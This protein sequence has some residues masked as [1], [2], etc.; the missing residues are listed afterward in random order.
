MWTEKAVFFQDHRF[1]HNLSTHF[2]YTRTLGRPFH[3]DWLWNKCKNM[4]NDKVI[5]PFKNHNLPDP[6]NFVTR[7]LG[8]RCTNW[9]LIFQKNEST[10]FVNWNWCS[11]ICINLIECLWNIDVISW[12]S[13]FL[14]MANQFTIAFQMKSV[15]KIADACR[16]SKINMIRIRNK[17]DKN[18]VT[19][20]YVS[21]I[22][23][24]SKISDKKCVITNIFWTEWN[25]SYA[26]ILQTMG[27]TAISSI[28]FHNNPFFSIFFHIPISDIIQSKI[29]F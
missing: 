17:Y 8:R 4:K 1:F 25:H 19:P 24:P 12:I 10:H 29:H 22:M 3:K 13:Y 15:K 9:I 7:A 18:I 23:I 2:D 5:F 6:N 20:E 21:F 28:I 27:I 16:I 26:S 14:N 11:V